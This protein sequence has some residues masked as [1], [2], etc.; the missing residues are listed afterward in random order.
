MRVDVNISVHGE[1]AAGCRVEVKN[2]AGTKNVER[3]VEYEFRRHVALLE[4]GSFPK[5]ETRRYDAASGTTHSLR[6]KSEDPD[7]RF[8]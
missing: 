1:K 3:A 8:F 5:P 2:V 6:D 7:Y 4:S